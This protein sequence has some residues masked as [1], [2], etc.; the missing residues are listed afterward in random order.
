M[1]MVRFGILCSFR[2]TLSQIC[3]INNVCAIRDKENTVFVPKM[4]C[5]SNHGQN[6]DGQICQNDQVG[7]FYKCAKF[8]AFITKCTIRPKSAISNWTTGIRDESAPMLGHEL[9]PMT[10]EYILTL[11]V[12][13]PPRVSALF[14][15]STA[16]RAH[17]FTRKKFRKIS[18]IQILKIP[19]KPC[20][21]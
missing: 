6:C 13:F 5:H 20:S 10:T 3:H 21:P 19:N 9:A 7:L 1:H 18:P 8:H 4:R 14:R 12:L 17:N 2:W 15:K 16:W 11:K